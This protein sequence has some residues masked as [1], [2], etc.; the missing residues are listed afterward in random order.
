MNRKGKPPFDP[1][2]FLAKVNGGERTISDYRKDQI[3]FRQ[4]DPS[5]SVFYIQSGKVKKTSSP[6]RGRKPWSHF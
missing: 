1:Q 3:L 2:V 5:D 4:G 6:S